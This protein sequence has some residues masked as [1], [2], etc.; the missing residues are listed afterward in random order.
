MK[1][2]ATISEA[3][4]ETFIGTTPTPDVYERPNFRK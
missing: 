3:L 2:N 1:S 4:A